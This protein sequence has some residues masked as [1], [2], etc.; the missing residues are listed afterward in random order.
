MPGTQGFPKA[1]PR[2]LARLPPY[3]P[4]EPPPPSIGHT[5]MCVWNVLECPLLYSLCYPS[6][7][8]LAPHTS[9]RKAPVVPNSSPSPCSPWHFPSTAVKWPFLVSPMPV[10]CVGSFGK[11]PSP[12]T[13]RMPCFYDLQSTFLTVISLCFVLFPHFA[14]EASETQRG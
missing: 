7:P 4:P 10:S 6:R 14:D 12:T 5:F 3:S 2:S 11:G 13:G 1:V 8:H 9:V